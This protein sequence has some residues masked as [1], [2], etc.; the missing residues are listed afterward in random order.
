M[1]KALPTVLTEF[2]NDFE[3]LRYRP[4]NR[5]TFRCSGFDSSV[6]VFGK[7]FADQRGELIHHD[8]M[9]L[10]AAARARHLDFKVAKPIKWDSATGTVWQ[11][12]IHGQ[13]LVD[14]LFSVSGAKLAGR[15]GMAAASLPASRLKP[16]TRFDGTA[17]MQR[18]I[19]YAKEL[20][21]RMPELADSIT[22]LIHT[23]HRI[24]ADSN[25][26]KLRAIHGAPH[27]HQWLDCG[28]QLGLVDFDRYCLGDPEL[29]AATF[30]GEM[31][32][33]DR[34]H[35]PVDK[36]NAIFL[37]AYQSI[38]GKLDFRLLQAY[39]SHKRLAKALK[40]AR[41]IRLNG[42]RKARRH[43]VYA[44]QAIKETV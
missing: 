15:I 16:T 5:C 22:R 34:E 39:H 10:W 28:D 43:L 3:I 2:N 17:Q 42:D 25:N 13:P 35:V 14:R 31:D 23:L 21:L 40:A 33:E 36:L 4:Y 30:I 12:A 41:S 1:L 7:L 8:S 20:S 19:K 11:A 24:H 37:D 32:F 38:A 18:S 6:P 29:D 26:H 27:A 9:S 44:F